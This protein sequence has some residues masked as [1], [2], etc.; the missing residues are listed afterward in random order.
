RW[1]FLHPIR[2]R[3]GSR[4]GGEHNPCSGGRY[5][6][7]PGQ[8]GVWASGARGTFYSCQP[9]ISVHEGKGKQCEEEGAIS[10]FCGIYSRRGGG[11][12]LPDAAP[13]DN[14]SFYDLLFSSEGS[15][16][17]AG[18]R[19]CARGRKLQNTDRYRRG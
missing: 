8:D 19:H 4:R 12:V 3:R 18:G 11:R 5:W 14:L 6:M 13:A 15:Q 17:G 10:P 9:H 2:D 1:C 16:E 7:V